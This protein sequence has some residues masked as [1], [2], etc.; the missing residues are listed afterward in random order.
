M[1]SFHEIIGQAPVR[2]SQAN[3]HTSQ[4]GEQVF[5]MTH[6][7]IST[8]NGSYTDHHPNLHVGNSQGL[9]TDVPMGPRVDARPS[10]FDNG[11]MNPQQPSHLFHDIQRPV[12]LRPQLDD[13]S[14][15]VA[16]GYHRPMGMN[17]LGSGTA[18]SVV[19]ADPRTPTAV[20]SPNHVFTT[21]TVSPNDSR[22]TYYT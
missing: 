21:G 20:M 22:L 3:A 19:T 14:S 16:S 18:L 6:F 15:E 12:S 1:L 17:G 8:P 11:R 4:V 13:S 7:N 9:Q 2:H 10:M 5:K